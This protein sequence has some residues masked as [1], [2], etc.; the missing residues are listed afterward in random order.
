MPSTWTVPSCAD[1]RTAAIL[2][3]QAHNVA[4]LM[5][6]CQHRSTIFIPASCCFKK[7]HNLFLA[8]SCFLQ[9]GLPFWQFSAVGKLC[10]DWACGR[11]K[12]HRHFTKPIRA[13]SLRV[14]SRACKS[15]K[16]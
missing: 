5:L 2:R 11:G 9:F 10:L 4:V 12:G 13:Y 14:C 7:A 16:V 15:S 3:R 8:E 1:G 6:R